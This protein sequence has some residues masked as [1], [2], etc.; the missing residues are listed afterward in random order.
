MS[1]RPIRETAYYAAVAAG[2]FLTLAV[3]IRL[4][5]KP[6]AVPF[7]YEGDALFWTVVVKATFEDGWAGHFRRIGMPFGVDYADYPSGMPFDFT[8]LRALMAATGEPGAA[9]NLYWLFSVSASGATA[10]YALRR[11]GLG[12]ALAFGLG[13]A[14]ALLPYGG[15]RNISHF[16]LVFHFIPLI[17]LLCLKIAEGGEDLDRGTRRLLLLACVLQGLS[18]V[19][20]SLFSCALLLAAGALGWL[21]QRRIETLRI[22]ALAVALIVVATTVSLLPSV[23]YWREHGRNPDLQYKAVA[24]ADTYGLKVRH[25]LIPIL[26]HPFPAFRRIAEAAYKAQFPGENENTSSRLGTTASL[27]FLLLIVFAVGAVAGAFPDAPPQVRSAAALTLVAVLVAQ[28]GGFGSLFN[29]LVAP[30]VRGYNRMVVFIAFFSLVAVGAAVSALAH[31]WRWPSSPA[32]GALA[33][34]AFLVLVGF[35]QIPRSYLTY[36]YADDTKRFREERAFVERVE[37]LLPEGAMVAQLP[38]TLVPVDDVPPPMSTYDHARAYLHSRKL[39]WSWGAITGRN[40][41]WHSGLAKLGPEELVPR[42]ALAGFSGLWLDRLGYGDRAQE[43]ESRIAEATGAPAVVSDD[44]RRVFFAFP[45]LAR[46]VATDLGPDRAATAR[47]LLFAPF[48]QR[49]DEGFS[50]LHGTGRHTTRA[51]GPNGR[52]VLTNPLDVERQVELRSRFS[53]VAGEGRLE[54]SGE[55]WQE[56]VDVST[57]S[58]AIRHPL[59]FGPRQTQTLRFRFTQ[60]PGP[61]PADPRDPVFLVVDFSIKEAF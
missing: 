19:Y 23:R 36:R 40:G 39:R 61:R 34:T 10:A 59:V 16:P 41:N 35:D 21:R 53:A 46:S 32:L 20:Y 1:L 31:R 7:S 37:S 17:A 56:A 26:D 47:R 14:Y 51:C 2:V 27:G 52:L 58:R 12:R 44:G 28:V 55:G 29:L 43:M 22:T 45:D 25:L 9:L 38:H 60:V 3:S 42:L 24:D 57:D 8:A 18:I 13:A 11:L 50:Y 5:E 6:L 49:W 48:D 30:D 15:Y 54:V 4:W 33:A